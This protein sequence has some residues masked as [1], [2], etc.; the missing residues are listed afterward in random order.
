MG[1]PRWSTPDQDTYL[2]SFLSGLDHAKVTTGLEVEYARIAA[3]FIVKWPA[4]PTVKH[5]RMTS[6]PEV[7]QE[8]AAAAQ[9]AVSP[10]F[11]AFTGTFSSV[12]QQI[13]EWYKT[14]R[15]TSAQAPQPKELLDLTGKAVRKPSPYQLHHAYSVRYF[16][17]ANSPLRKEVDD[18]WER[19][20]DKTV[21]DLLSPFLKTDNSGDKQLNFHNAIMRWKCSLLNKEE[22]QEMEDWIAD[23]VLKKG[24]EISK[25]WKVGLGEDGDELSVENEY[26]QRCVSL[27]SDSNAFN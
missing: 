21:I 24:E 26:I 3:L 10:F 19:Q 23:A 2:E 4:K 18:L 11:G 27:A 22:L 14:R 16:R 20:A 6:D 25:P 7:L 8:L 5:Q 15:K 1:R 17:P 13:K 12:C 9:K